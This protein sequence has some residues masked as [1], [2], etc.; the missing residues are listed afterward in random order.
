MSTTFINNGN[1]VISD[2][3]SF[4]GS[5]YQSG[6]TYYQYF[7]PVPISV[8]STDTIN[9]YFPPPTSG[10]G[11][12]TPFTSEKYTH[13]AELSG[14]GNLVSIWGKN[15]NTVPVIVSVSFSDSSGNITSNNPNSFSTTV[16]TVVVPSNGYFDMTFWAASPHLGLTAIWAATAGSGTVKYYYGI[17]Y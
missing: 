10:N 14:K 5:N 2:T 1:Y 11:Q 17:S 16:N 12:I 4:V 9:V 13:I 6:G 7:R 15:N 8:E 3:E